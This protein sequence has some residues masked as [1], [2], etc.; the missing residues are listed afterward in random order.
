MLMG[1]ASIIIKLLQATRETRAPEQCRS[2]AK[3]AWRLLQGE[4]PCRV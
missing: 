3:Q 1:E 2:R 4:S